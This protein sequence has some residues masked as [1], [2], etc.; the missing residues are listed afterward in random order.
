MIPEISSLLTKHYIKAGF[1]AEEYIVL[2]A[3]LNH[4]K[5]FQ[6]KHN[7]NEV[8]EM[9][10]KTLNE[11]QDILENLLKKELINMDP[12]KET[13]DLLTLHNRLHELDFEAK[14]INKRIFDSIN[15][16]RH[17]SSDPYY[18]HFGQVTL[19]PFTDGGIGVTSG[20][21]RLYGDLMWSR[22]DMKKLADE[23]L[24]LVE[25]ID[26]TRIDEYNNDLKEKRRIEK[27]QQRIAYEERK[28]QREQPVKPKHGYVVLIRL[29]PSGHYKFTYTVSADLNGK[30][31]R[32]KEEYGSNVEIVHSVE[33]YDTLKF[34]HQFAKK[35]FSN[36][37]IEKTL[38]QL[39]EEDVQFFKDEKYPANAMDW[40]EGSRVK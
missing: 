31:N 28:A 21:N 6:D 26:Q 16:S 1:T 29:Y 37:L 13:I 10:G 5:V 27:E 15:D 7:L 20:T 23:I 30:I 22:N 24:D 14:T 25:K 9:T 4:S 39:T 35:Q 19:V 40:L 12:E 2:N 34:Y 18:Q 11:I 36:R 32:L 17:F 33:T 3:Y 8:A 38:Y